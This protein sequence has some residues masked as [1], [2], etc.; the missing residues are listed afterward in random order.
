[1]T[2]ELA[3]KVKN[4]EFTIFNIKL[5]VLS[6]AKL[7]DS[8]EDD[9]QLHMTK[10]QCTMVYSVLS[11]TASRLREWYKTLGEVQE[12][13]E[14]GARELPVTEHPKEQEAPR[15]PSCGKHVNEVDFEKYGCCGDCM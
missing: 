2:K 3:E 13:V 15:C 8:T 5:E 14:L 10:E 1:M 11:T 7:L 9:V 6:L 12:L 4:S